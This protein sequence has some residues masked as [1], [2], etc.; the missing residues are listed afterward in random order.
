[1]NNEMVINT[2]LSTIES[3]EQNKWTAEQKQNQRHRE[4]FDG[5]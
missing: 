4:H 1:M 2:Y 3:K 5:C